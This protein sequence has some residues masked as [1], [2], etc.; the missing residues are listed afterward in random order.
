MDQTPPAED[1]SRLVR[2][3]ARV[4]RLPPDRQRAIALLLAAA[5]TAVLV[6]GLLAA[7]A[8]LG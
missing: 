4:R 7:R 5:A 8:A 3:V 1:P 2:F 6:G